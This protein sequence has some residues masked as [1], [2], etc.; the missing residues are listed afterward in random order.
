MKINHLI[1]TS[2]LILF[3]STNSLEPCSW[4]FAGSYAI[5]TA[6][7]SFF[8]IGNNTASASTSIDY[9]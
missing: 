2:M 8:A 5:M 6:A 7:T 4:F 1:F 9:R 3:E